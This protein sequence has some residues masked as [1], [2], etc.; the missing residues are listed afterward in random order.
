MRVTGGR[1]FTRPS[2]LPL[3]V[4]LLAVPSWAQDRVDGYVPPPKDLKQIGDHWTPYSAPQ[5]DAASKVHLIQG[6]DS[7]WSLAQQYY[8]DP[9]L[10]P[11]LW[12]ANRYVLYSHWIYPG[13]P[14]IVPGK[15][16]QVADATPAPTPTATPAAAWTENSGD[17]NAAAAEAPAA[18]P[19]TRSGPMLVPAAEQQEIACAGQLYDHFDPNPLQISGRETTDRQMQSALDIVYLS[20]GRDMNVQAGDEYVVIRRGKEIK[21]PLTNKPAAIY[22]QRVGRLKVL[23]VLANS[24]IA[25]VTLSCDGVLKGDYL[26]PYKEMPVPMVERQPLAMFETADAARLS[27]TVL[28]SHDDRSTF[29]GSGDLVGIDLGAGAGLTA[30]D[31]VYFWH[32]QEGTEARRLVAQGVVLATNGGGSTVKILEARSEVRIGDAAEVH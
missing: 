5:P 3:W 14:L 16:N 30:G 17:E 26:V 7:L 8:G 6:G 28:V 4:A 10:W 13:D 21:H 31:R 32:A 12:D 18:T 20:A 19:P 23:A 22:V 9:Y 15:P 1:R 24:S 2:V 27:G 29:S 25:E 11:T